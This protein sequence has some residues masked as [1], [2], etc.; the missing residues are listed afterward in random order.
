MDKTEWHSYN[1][2]VKWMKEITPNKSQEK[3][4]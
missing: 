2:S 1:Q 4:L 3:N